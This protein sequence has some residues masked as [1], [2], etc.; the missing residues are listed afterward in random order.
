MSAIMYSKVIKT[1]CNQV[2][3]WPAIFSAKL[4]AGIQRQKPSPQREQPF[5]KQL[6]VFLFSSVSSS[7]HLP[8]SFASFFTFLSSLLTA[9]LQQPS[10]NR[11][12]GMSQTWGSSHHFIFDCLF[13]LGLLK[14]NTRGGQK[15]GC[16]LGRVSGGIGKWNEIFGE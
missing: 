10:K 16:V 15:L 5:W 13:T 9:Y 4:Q 1:A 7:A 8:S 2:P 11:P 14:E 3:S 6:S 12:K